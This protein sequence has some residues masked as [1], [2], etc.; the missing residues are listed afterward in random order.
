[1]SRKDNEQDLPE[2]WKAVGSSG[3]LYRKFEFDAYDGTREFLD[4][5]A[6]LSEDTGIYPDLSFASKHVNVTIHAPDEGESKDPQ[7]KF[8]ADAAALISG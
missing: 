8:A 7:H 3:T 1:M 4:K 6:E 5:L 2:G